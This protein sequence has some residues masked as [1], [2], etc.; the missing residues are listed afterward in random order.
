MVK[1]QFMKT[2]VSA[3]SAWLLLVDSEV[4]DRVVEFLIAT[5]PAHSDVV[6]SLLRMLLIANTSIFQ[7]SPVTVSLSDLDTH[8]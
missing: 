5:Y 8:V 1:T 4:M 7:K 3:S 6:V 2:E